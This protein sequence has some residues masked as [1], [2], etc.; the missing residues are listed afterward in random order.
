M[1]EEV[2]RRR[3]RWW[4]ILPIFFSIIGGIISFF[5]IRHDDPE[6][7]RNCLIVGI[8]LFILP[9]IIPIIFVTAFG[10]WEIINDFE[11]E[12]MMGLPEDVL[13]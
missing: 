7:A 10:S 5:A 3:S 9:I 8:V 11:R 2:L 12:L 1:T 6:K 13:I 4:Y